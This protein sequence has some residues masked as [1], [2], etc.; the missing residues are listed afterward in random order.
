MC[1]IGQSNGCTLRLQAVRCLAP[2]LILQRLTDRCAVCA[3]Q[4]LSCGLQWLTVCCAVLCC[5]VSV[6]ADVFEDAD[7]MRGPATRK[8]HQSGKQPANIEMRHARGCRKYHP[9]CF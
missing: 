9:R 5:A 8:L 4:R 2:E 1:Q 6:C 3:V 7:S